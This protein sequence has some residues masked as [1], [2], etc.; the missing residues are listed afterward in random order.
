VSRPSLRQSVRDFLLVVAMALFIRP[1][2]YWMPASLPFL[3]LGETIFPQRVTLQRMSGMQA[4]LL[5]HWRVRLRESN[6]VRSGTAAVFARELGL[7]R[8]RHPYLRLP[9]YASSPDEKRA[10]LA[11]S[12]RL[13]LG[14]SAGYPAALD[15]IPEMRAW[16][17]GVQCPQARRVASLL[18]TVPVHHWLRPRDRQAICECLRTT[19]TPV[20]GD[21][22][23]SHAS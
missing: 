20:S 5:R 7:D 6:H 10:C 18:L 15:Q 19:A 4:G 14:L 11:R 9:I 16:S 23:F 2:L 3:R 21:A 13:G 1:S 17:S 22:E 8:P 12:Q